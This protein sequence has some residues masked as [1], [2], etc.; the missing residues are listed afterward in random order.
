MKKSQFFRK[1]FAAALS[2]AMVLR[3]LT[4]YTAAQE[5]VFSTGSRIRVDLNANDGRQNSYTNNAYNWIVSGTTP[6]AVFNGVTFKLSNGGNTG[7]VYKRQVLTL[8]QHEEIIT[9][10]FLFSISFSYSLLTMVAPM[11][12][13]PASLKPSFFDA[14]L[15]ISMLMPL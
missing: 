12:V 13:S 14:L 10:C 6:T 1:M 9:L 7:D 3:R 8:W 4:G 5:P 2:A 11:A 15:I